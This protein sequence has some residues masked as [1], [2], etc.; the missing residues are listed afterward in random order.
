MGKSAQSLKVDIALLLF[1][2]EQKFIYIH[3]AHF[4]NFFRDLCYAISMYNNKLS[5]NVCD[6]ERLSHLKNMSRERERSMKYIAKQILLRDESEL[7]SYSW[8]VLLI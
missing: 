6:S 1:Y 7:G 5:D 4:K 3:R 8:N 2:D